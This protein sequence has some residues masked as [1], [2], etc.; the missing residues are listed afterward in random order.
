MG[1]GK[2]GTEGGSVREGESERGRERDE[3]A[4][5]GSDASSSS[6]SSSSSSKEVAVGP[7]VRV[8]PVT[9]QLQQ[10]VSNTTW[11]RV[12]NLTTGLLS[13]RCMAELIFKAPA[14]T[15]RVL[16]CRQAH[17]AIEI[18]TVTRHSLMAEL[19]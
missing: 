15:V 7:V 14:F 12:H 10:K 13:G 17:L 16:I 9:G 6:S 11:R 19:L 3:Q 18:M 4:V 8:D 5:G 1:V 2:G